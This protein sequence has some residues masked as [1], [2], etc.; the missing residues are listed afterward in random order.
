LGADSTQIPLYPRRHR[1]SNAFPASGASFL[2][3]GQTEGNSQISCLHLE[4]G[5]KV[6]APSLTHA[7]ALLVVHGR[8]TVTTQIP[9]TQINID[10]GS[11][12]VFEKHE[13]YSLKSEG[14][15]L[16]IVESRELTAHERAISTPHP[17]Y[18]N[19]PTNRSSH[20]AERHVIVLKETF[21]NAQ[22]RLDQ[23]SPRGS[24]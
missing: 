2:P 16:L 8:I 4:K 7:A 9:N 11:G 15:I 1:P 19:A 14:A 17:R 6:P 22:Q 23:S 10:A 12:C 20:L 5:A 13:P 24:P 18:L 3:L 21:K